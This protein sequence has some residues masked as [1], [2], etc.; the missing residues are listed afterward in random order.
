MNACRKY[1]YKWNDCSDIAGSAPSCFDDPRADVVFQ[2]AVAWFQDRFAPLDTDPATTNKEEDKFDVIIMG[3]VLEHVDDHHPVEGG[4]GELEGLTVLDD[5]ANVGQVPVDLTREADVF[6]ADITGLAE[7]PL[8]IGPQ[9]LPL[10][11]PKL[12]GVNC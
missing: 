11:W 4:V 3:F 2:D 8:G 10:P 6:F 1:L 12:E 9:Q 7:W 5:V